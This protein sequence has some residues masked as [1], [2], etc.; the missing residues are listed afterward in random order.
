MFQRPSKQREKTPS[1]KDTYERALHEQLDYLME[2]LLNC[3]TQDGQCD[4]CLRCQAINRQLM[5][6][7]E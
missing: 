3:H 1:R 5:K 6:A 4:T 2:H 7:W